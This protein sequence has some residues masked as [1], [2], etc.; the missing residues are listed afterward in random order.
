MSHPIPNLSLAELPHEHGFGVLRRIN[1]ITK[2]QQLPLND[3][4]LR[5][6]LGAGKVNGHEVSAGLIQE[7]LTSTHLMKRSQLTE[8]LDSGIRV[9]LL[10]DSDCDETH[11]FVDGY[12]ANSRH[13]GANVVAN[14]WRIRGSAPR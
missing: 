5:R 2:W 8:M 11:P 3:K 6:R 12:L 1:T 14:L 10:S 9:K 7:A 13:R 4:K